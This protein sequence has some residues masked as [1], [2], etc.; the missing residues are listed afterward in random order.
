VRTEVDTQRVA[1]QAFQDKKI[2]SELV[3]GIFSKKDE[4]RYTSFKALVLISEQHPDLLYPQWDIFAGLL[5]SDNA[6]HKQIAIYLLAN[7]TRV[8]AQH[9]FENIGDTYFD[10]LNS[11]SVMNAGH[12]AVNLGK[13]VKTKPHLQQKITNLLLNIE[14]TYPIKERVDLVIGYVIEAFDTYFEDA[15]DK[16]KIRNFVTKQ[17]ASK[18]PKT[19]KK[20]KEFL[21]KW[22]SYV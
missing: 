12:L 3:K 2:L 14:K 8:D 11:T 4:T 16:D 5:E 22:E 7:L 18:S 15:E 19:R 10:L 13:I 1:N 6:Y 9:K 20:A 17:V 21:K